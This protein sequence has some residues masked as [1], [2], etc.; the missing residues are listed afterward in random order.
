MT[1]RKILRAGAG[2]ALALAVAGC[3]NDKLTALNA[4]PNSPE[5]VPPGPLFTNAARVS[6]ARWF[7]GY[8][9]RTAEWI[10]QQLAEVQY[11]DEDIYVR[12]HAA[13]TEG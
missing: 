5:L 6:V 1:N 8:D 12:F 13:D 7:G 4:N 9:L 3:N 2:V 11:T 10:T